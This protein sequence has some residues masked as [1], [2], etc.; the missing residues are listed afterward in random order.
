MTQEQRS[1]EVDS[2][3]TFTA[4]L[5]WLETGPVPN[6]AMSTGCAV[7]QGEQVGVQLAVYKSQ[8]RI[9]LLVQLQRI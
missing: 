6:I 4:L 9:A 8:H 3:P 5:S 1:T 7:K 2:H